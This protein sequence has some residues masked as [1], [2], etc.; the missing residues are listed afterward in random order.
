MVSSFLQ[1]LEKKYKDNL[2][3]T[4]SRY[5]QFA[6]DGANRMKRLILDLLEYSRVGTN[7]DL[8]ADTDMNIVME[9]VLGNLKVKLEELHGVVHYDHLP[10]LPNTRRTQLVQLM[11]NLIGNSLKYH[12]ERPPEIIVSAQEEAD[13]WVFS[14]KD[15]GIGF[16]M[17]FAEKIFVIFQRLHNNSEYS[18]TGI[19]LSICK[20]IV[21][22]YGGRIWVESLPGVG[23]TFYFSISRH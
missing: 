9:E 11:Q 17:K 2:D 1:L 10:V 14:I 12:S 5:I 18:G 6:V 21:E 22:R 20:K 4:A 8:A 13:S 7:N 15:N 16:D 23:S 19:G 3:E